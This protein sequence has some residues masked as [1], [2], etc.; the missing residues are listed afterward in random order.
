MKAFARAFPKAIE[1]RYQSFYLLPILT[2]A[3]LC[4]LYP[5]NR[6]LGQD[7]LYT[8]VHFVEVRSLW[9]TIFS[10][11]A[12]NNHIGY[13]LMARFSEGL[14]GRSE[15][16]LRLPALL[17]GMAT[18]YIFFVFGRS[19]L[20]HIPALLGTLVLAPQF[21]RR[22]GLERAP[23]SA[24]KGIV[25]GLWGHGGRLLIVWP[26]GYGLDARHFKSGRGIAANAVKS[27]RSGVCCRQDAT[28]LSPN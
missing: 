5:L 25:G 20:G 1:T 19:I 9:K 22:S 4:R 14:L 10:N 23:A 13:S 3:L 16:A 6:G 27:F 24:A 18:L 26:S 2:V 17:L 7:E 28:L 8:A 15:W 11:D 12:F 21:P